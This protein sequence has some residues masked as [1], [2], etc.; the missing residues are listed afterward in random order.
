M[1]LETIQK[2]LCE[3]GTTKARPNESGRVIC[4]L[5]R[6][7][8]LPARDA[9]SDGLHFVRNDVTLLHNISYKVKDQIYR[10]I[11]RPVFK[12]TMKDYF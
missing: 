12:Y 5:P 11:C 3:G 7:K 6:L 10:I 4:I 9:K 8:E 2:H 1:L